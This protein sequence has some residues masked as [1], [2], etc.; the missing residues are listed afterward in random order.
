MDPQRPYADP[1]GRPPPADFPAFHLPPQ[2]GV[3]RHPTP[4]GGEIHALPDCHQH[5]ILGEHQNQRISMLAQQANRVPTPESS[6]ANGWGSQMDYSLCCL[7]LV[8]PYL[9]TLLTS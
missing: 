6:F 9:L 8:D 1:H 4:G 5:H 7:L 3:R 2:D